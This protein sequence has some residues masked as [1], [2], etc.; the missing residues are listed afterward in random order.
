M[1]SMENNTE[2][3]VYDQFTQCS[4][5]SSHSRRLQIVCF[6]VLQFSSE[7]PLKRAGV[8]VVK[9]FINFYRTLQ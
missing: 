9:Y 5:N 1:K 3:A 8:V 7:I 4:L 6:V 2:I